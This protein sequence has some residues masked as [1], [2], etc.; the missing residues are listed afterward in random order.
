[1]I[2]PTRTHAVGRKRARPA[3]T[4]TLAVLL[5]ST[6]LV[7]T[8]TADHLGC[9]DTITTDTKLT[10]D[11]GPCPG[12]GLLVTADG[13]TLDLNGH[14]VSGA[15]GDG[16]NVGIRLVMASGVTV[17]NGTVTGFDAGVELHQSHGNTIRQ[18]VVRDNI[19][20]FGS[21]PCDLGDGI[22]VGGSHGN[23]VE[24]N[25]VIHNGP[26]GGI[27]LLGDAD[28]NIVRNNQVSDNNIVT[29]PGRTGCGNRFQDE[30]IRVEGPGAERNRIE[31]NVVTN[32]VLAGIGLHGTVCN[33]PNPALPPQPF[34]QD[35]VLVGNRVSHT[36][37]TSIASGINILR[38]G[39]AAIVCPARRTTIVGNTSSDNQ[40]DGIFVSNNSDGNVI[41][42]N[43]VERNGLSGIFLMG[44]AFANQFTNVGPTEF[45]VVSPDLPPYTED[46]HY[47]VM[48]GS[49][50]GDVTGRLV[51][52]DIVL[53]P[54][55]DRN[56]NPNPP[57]TSTSGCEQADY[58]AA[59]FNTG[60]VALLQR[61]TCTFVSKLANA[62]EAGASAVVMFNE[63]QAEFNRTTHRFGAVGP[64]PIPA[65]TTEYS[66]GFDLYELTQ[67][68]EVT[69]HIET[70]TINELVF[71][72][73]GANNT[74]LMDNRGRDNGDFDGE[75]ANPNCAPVP[76]DPTT[77]TNDWFRNW[78]GSVNQDCVATGG[79]GRGGG[80]GKSGDA[81]GRLDGG[82]QEHN[83]GHGGT[84][85]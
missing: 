17:R 12:D 13:I 7:S 73:P 66:V 82:G 61:G 38:Q 58:A 62:V 32:S 25:Q 15:N 8:A 1:M 24:H 5:L 2:A 27:T 29:P 22:V 79:T 20:D 11:I 33:P 84:A 30:G 48:P 71:V 6:L 31:R 45:D 54:D 41:N 80:P 60:D 39:P 83:R 18:L 21:P 10:H 51:P 72:A 78:F 65:L 49:G 35:N 19:N 59:G 63:G 36:A 43:T 42:R 23:V 74:T 40:A 56:N 3:V 85:S 67:A 4:I 81:P 34:N 55:A 44:P 50:S 47:R 26:Y 77:W 68:G 46:V 52:I 57:N 14:T 75:D 37:G 28:D 16:D 9:G 64:Q 70:N 53:H 76:E 69:V